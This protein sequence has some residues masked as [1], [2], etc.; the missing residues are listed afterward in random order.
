[1][2]PSRCRTNGTARLSWGAIRQQQQDALS[3][4]LADLERVRRQSVILNDEAV[5]EI[6]RVAAL[7]LSLQPDNSDAKALLLKAEEK[8]GKLAERLMSEAK[9]F[10]PSYRQK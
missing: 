9:P 7:V 10:L 4:V 6:R 2:K 5:F 1:M 3:R 8:A